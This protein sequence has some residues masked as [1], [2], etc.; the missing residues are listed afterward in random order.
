LTAKSHNYISS[1]ESILEE[2]P[3][4]KEDKK[5]RVSRTV[6]LSRLVN[7]NAY[8]RKFYLDLGARSYKTS[9]A[10]FKNNYPHFDKFKTIAF[11]ADPIFHKEYLKYREITYYPLAVWIRNE[12]VTFRAGMAH[13]TNEKVCDDEEVD[14]CF[15]SSALLKHDTTLKKGKSTRQQYFTTQ[16][17]DFSEYLFRN[18]KVTDFIVVKMDIEGAEFEVVRHLINT[19]AVGLIDELFLEGH[20]PELNGIKGISVGHTYSEIFDLLGELRELGVHAHEWF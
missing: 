5:R 10:W 12:T 20:T 7:L 15:Q 3:N 1:L 4:G 11:E 2:A 8:E 6:F 19:G 18:F 14:D 16:A 17:F 9:I 13:I